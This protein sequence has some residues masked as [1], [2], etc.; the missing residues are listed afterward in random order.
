ML[1]MN[2]TDHL[3]PQPGL[4]RVLAEANQIQDDFELAITTLPEYLARRADGRAAA[5]ARRA[6][7]GLPH[8]PAHGG[9]LQPGRR[10]AGR[11]QGGAVA[12]ASGRAALRALPAGPSVARQLPRPRLETGHPQFGPRLGLRLFGRRRGR[13]GAPPLRRGTPDRRGARG[14]RPRSDRG[15][16]VRHRG[17]WSS[18]R[19]TATGE[20]WS[21]WS[22]PRSAKP[23][24][25]IQV[26]SE[27]AG[28]PGTVTLDGETVR[29]MLGMIQGARIDDDTYITDVTLT[30]EEPDLVD[31]PLDRHR[32]ARRRPGRGGQARAVHPL[33]RAAGHPG[34]R[35]D[36][37][38]A[39]PP[40]PRHPG[41]GPRVRL[42]AL[43]AVAPR[44]SRRGRPAIPPPASPS[45]TAWSR[46]SSTRR[47]APSR[48]TACPATGAWSTTGTTATPT[49]TRRRPTMPS[50]THRNRWWSRRV[51]RDRCGRPR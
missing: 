31:H 3:R 29:G 34:P 25:D 45:A 21:R 9:R 42:V 7:L 12:R 16:H 4:G 48:S 23:G 35:R 5:L 8:Q 50:S 41:R 14:R 26:L 17:R 38:A 28:L 37:P 24:P 6:P 46:W 18:T 27:R 47:T 33:D 39:D 1:L 43:L 44:P 13:R 49:T 15:L 30:E 20:G 36:R 19:P 32:A 2:G 10:Q 51:T 40:G 22:F 11:G